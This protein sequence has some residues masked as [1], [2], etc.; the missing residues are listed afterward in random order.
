M[1]VVRRRSKRQQE[2]IQTLTFFSFVLL[3]IG[4][5]IGYLWVYME[6][7]ETLL[8]IEIH[9]KT[10]R[11]LN[12]ELKELRSEIDYLSRVDVISKKARTELDMVPATPETLIVYLDEIAYEGWND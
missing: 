2:L 4:G 7:D 6:V 1:S 9:N 12:N 10:A 11:A 3:L 5:L 8:N